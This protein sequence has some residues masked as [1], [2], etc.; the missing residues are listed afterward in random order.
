MHANETNDS[1]PADAA[2][3]H[4]A[5]IDVHNH[6]M[7]LPLLEWLER[8]GLSEAWMCCVPTTLPYYA[9][10]GVRCQWISEEA[11]GLTSAEAPG[12]WRSERDTVVAP[13]GVGMRAQA[14]C[15]VTMKAESWP[16]ENWFY[17]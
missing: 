4:P 1:Q 13:R 12:T 17:R 9:Q 2:G 10:R 3:V 8:S 11:T 15:S 5:A 7:P 14:N 6:A 16:A